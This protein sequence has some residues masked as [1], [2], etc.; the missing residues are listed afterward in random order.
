[1]S[2]IGLRKGERGLEVIIAEPANALTIPVGAND[3]LVSEP[4]DAF[5]D[6]V[7]VA[8]SG[9]WLDDH[10]VRVELIFLEAPHR[11]DIT[12]TLPA[13]TAEAV[14]RHRPLEARIATQHRPR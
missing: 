6:A 1:L 9:G 13:R 8:A 10:T 3:W 2:S 5:G 11:M 14:W 12:C 4:R 7:P